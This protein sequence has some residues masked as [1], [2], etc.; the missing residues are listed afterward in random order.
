MSKLATYRTIR[1]NAARFSEMSAF[2]VSVTW[3][4]SGSGPGLLIECQKRLLV[5]REHARASRESTGRDAVRFEIYPAENHIGGDRRDP[6]TRTVRP[7]NVVQPDVSKRA[8][9][10]PINPK[11]I[12]ANRYDIQ[13]EDQI[14]KPRE[15]GQ[16][17][18]QR[19]L[20]QRIVN[21]W[22]GECH[23][24]PRVLI[25][26]DAGEHVGGPDEQNFGLRGQRLYRL[27][28]ECGP[29]AHPRQREHHRDCRRAERPD[30][31]P[32]PSPGTRPHTV[33]SCTHG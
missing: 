28:R 19:L 2:R 11:S 30:Q 15:S 5:A 18:R 26:P 7:I 1:C 25:W 9:S 33:E 22:R 27:G 10:P 31:A 32:P 29:R 6:V 23:F 4:S 13:L 14:P 17:L 16:M 12:I 20:H 3:A 24:L 8:V 21:D